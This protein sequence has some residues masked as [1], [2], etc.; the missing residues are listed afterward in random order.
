MTDRAE[1]SEP[2]KTGLLSNNRERIAG[3][4]GVERDTVERNLDTEGPTDRHRPRPERLAGT[5][6]REATSYRT[7]RGSAV[8]RILKPMR[9]DCEVRPCCPSHGLPRFPVALSAI[10]TN[11]KRQ[12]GHSLNSLRW[13][14]G[15]V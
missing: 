2:S 8:K 6:R 12:R 15:L 9:V 1:A 13:R 11:P 10:Q 5:T 4:C 3:E 14:F 7:V